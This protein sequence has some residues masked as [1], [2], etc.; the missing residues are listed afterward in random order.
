MNESKFIKIILRVFIY[1]LF[2]SSMVKCANPVSPTGG[3]KDEHPP[4]VVSSEPKN[5]S[6]HFSKKEMS[7]TFNEFIQLKD[8]QKQ[9]LISPPIKYRPEIKIKKKSVVIKLNK[10]ELL[11]E[12][13]TYTIFLGNAIVDLTESNHYLNFEYV[14]STGD[15][16][17]SLSINGVV[18][19]MLSGLPVENVS[20]MLYSNNNDSIPL[21]SLPIRVRPDYVA[22]TDLNGNFSLNNLKN[23]PYKIFALNDQ[24]SNYLYDLP[25]E[26][27]A[28]M[29]SMIQPY[30]T[31]LRISPE[32]DSMLI[33]STTLHSDLYHPP[34]LLY[35]FT[36]I[37]STQKIKNY[38][39]LDDFKIQ[40]LLDFPCANYTINPLNFDSGID[41]KIDEFNLHKDSILIWVKQV[42]P[43]TIKLE[44]IADGAVL[45]TL[46][47]KVKK[48]QTV[49]TI[50]KSLF[51]K[52]T[53]DT[54]VQGFPFIFKPNIQNNKVEFNN[55]IKIEFN[56]PLETYDF[57]SFIWKEDT[58]VFKPI[59]RFADS[60]KRHII[61]END[62]LEKVNYKLIIPDSTLSHIHGTYNDSI[63]YNFS[64]KTKDQYGNIIL[65]ITPEQNNVH[66]IIQ[67]MNSKDIILMEKTITEKQTILFEYLKP[68]KYKLRAILDQNKNGRWDT[69]NYS[70]KRHAEKIIYLNAEIQLRANWD[71]EE[72][73]TLK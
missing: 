50:N 60:V 14:F 17:D 40:I 20:V 25:Y 68:G 7:V 37:D 63:I 15:F 30:Y 35:L 46:E 48:K 22:K 44:F 9:L 55:K 1:G 26:E 52:K 65:K 23:T 41:W 29:D 5:Y 67:L 16:V 59:V 51:K 39:V 62:L 33:D 64:T 21:D 45:D 54:V 32:I 71:Y 27:I 70:F 28:F 31:G 4:R 56:Y 6:S 36:K 11:K 47:F 53:V 58:M 12:N 49:S 69:G 34:V 66:W 38:T 61:I 73:W 3:P 72:S 24:N 18:R 10:N 19:N 42:V 13:T 57:S 8:L 43:D 2:I